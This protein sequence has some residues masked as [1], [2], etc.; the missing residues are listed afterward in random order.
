MGSNRYDVI[1]VGGGPAG[2]AAAIAAARKGARTALIE[3]CGFLGGVWTAGL[4]TYVLDPSLQN[5]VLGELISRLRSIPDHGVSFVPETSPVYHDPGV[6]ES[7]LYDT[8][9][10]K[11]VLENWVLEEGVHLRLYTT[12][13][14]VSLARSDSRRIASIQTHSKSGVETWTAPVFVD[15]TGDGDLGA[16]SGARFTMGRPSD[17][18]VQPMTLHCLV[19]GV[20]VEE[21]QEF[22]SFA[23]Y[24]DRPPERALFA[25]LAANG[26]TPTYANPALFAVHR[27][28][29]ALMA[30]HQYSRSA[31]DAQDLTDASVSA[32]REIQQMMAAF[33]RAG[34]PWSSLRL[35]ATAPRIGV[36]EGRRLR[37]IYTITVDDLVDGR[38]QD[39]AVCRVN[40]PVDIHSLDPEAGVGYSTEG[41]QAKPYDIP[42]RAL[43]SADLDNLFMAG[44]CISGDFFAHASYRVTGNAVETGAAAGFLAAEAV[45]TTH[46]PAR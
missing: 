12:L 2:F 44:R 13:Q 31:L 28:L 8:E 9:V 33:R 38:R 18:K 39:D 15:C 30:N 24:G 14:G 22:V 5:P 6:A 45:P 32:R 36:R 29:F 46:S 42:A 1:V 21:I 4:L 17:G 3:Q 37:G 19:A 11:H 20:S 23:H 43:I 40:F 26:Y 35:V 34:P 7:F 16:V 10:M 27:D 25:L 41:V